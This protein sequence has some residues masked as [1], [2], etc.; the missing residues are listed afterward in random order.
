MVWWRAVHIIEFAH[1]GKY[2]G[3]KTLFWYPLDAVTGTYHSVA[4]LRF[5]VGAAVFVEIQR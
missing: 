4:L 5:R 2:G 1:P 3:T